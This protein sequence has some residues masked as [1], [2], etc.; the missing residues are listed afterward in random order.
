[1]LVEVRLQSGSCLVEGGVHNGACGC[2]GLGVWGVGL[3]TVGRVKHFEI[4]WLPVDES[5]GML[6]NKVE[7]EADD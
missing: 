2:D 3:I 5:V 4:P 7:C 1:M 6:G